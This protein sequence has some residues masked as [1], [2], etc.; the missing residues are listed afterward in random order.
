MCT[1]VHSIP[2]SLQLKPNPSV[3]SI[4]CQLCRWTELGIYVRGAARNRNNGNKREATHANTHTY[5]NRN[6][7]RRRERE[8]KKEREMILFRKKSLQRPTQIDTIKHQTR[9][10]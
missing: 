8:G 1:L 7:D 6:K 5:R 4:R 10:K 9:V 3:T 2:I